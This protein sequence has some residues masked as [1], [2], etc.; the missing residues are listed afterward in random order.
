MK[1]QAIIPAAGLGNRMNSKTPKPF[2]ELDGK[3][4]II[5]TL[6]VLEQC[7]SIESVILV[8]SRDKADQFKELVDQYRLKKVIEYIAGGKTR[9]ESVCNGLSYVAPETKL[10]V[11]HD[12]ARPLI[13]VDL[14]EKAITQCITEDAV[15]VA[16]PVKPTIKKVNLADLNVEKT[17]ERE[18]LWE[19]QTPQIFKRE[20]LIDAFEQAKDFTATD[21]SVLV[22]QLGIKVKVVEGDYRNIKVTTL[23]DVKIAEVLKS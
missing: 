15:V 5:H 13:S 10:V 23:E 9:S 20:V 3:P 14:M 2:I 19:I 18:K 21:E 22:E 6:E 12:G 4:I 11:V 17:L 7:P 8:V 16:V 1:V